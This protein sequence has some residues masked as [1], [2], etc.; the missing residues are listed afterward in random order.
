[1]TIDFQQSLL[2]YLVQFPDGVTYVNDLDDDLFDLIEYKLTLQ[3]LKKYHKLY[4]TLPGKISA[5]QYLEEQISETPDLSKEVARDL[6]EVFED[7]Y[8]PIQPNDR[9]KIQDTL[10]L[11]IQQ[12]QIETS[13]MDFASGKLSVYQVFTKMNKLSSLVKTAGFDTH[14]DGGFLVMDRER[15]YDEQVQGNPTFL[16]ELNNLTAARGFYSP[17][18]VIFMSGPKSFKTGL[19]INLAVE[20]ARE[21][22]KVYY[23]DGENG[24]RSIRNRSKQC[25][26]NCTYEELYDSDIQE[27][28]NEVLY[29]FGLYMGGDVFIDSYPAGT[30][31]ISDVR[32]RL[33]YLRE[34]YNWV[35]DI[36]IY[37]SIDHFIPSNSADRGRDTRIKIQLVYHEAINLNREL[38]VFSIAPSQV[39]R[40]ALSKKV[41]D[42]KDLSEDFGKAMNAHCIM[43][44]CATPEEIDQGIRRIVPVAQREGVAYKGKNFCFIKVDEERMQVEEVDKEQYLSNINDN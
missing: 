6:R 43:A 18:L 31:S 4:G 15:H 2:S 22:K 17:Q 26:M 19:L 32:N 42:M 39:N 27:E 14:S 24:A 20:Y 8:F 36:I 5:Q 29:H 28:L 35:P 10:I 40:D 13:F 21:G 23:A 3:I 37:D 7:L 38:N 11:E 25:I 44:I 41:F 1:M 33:A 34:E 30:K 12:R 9:L 16:T